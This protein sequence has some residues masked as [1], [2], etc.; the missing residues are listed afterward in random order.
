MN[1]MIVAAAGKRPLWS[2]RIAVIALA[3]III[4][5]MNLGLMTAGSEFGRI[6]W[7]LI[8]L[9][10]RFIHPAL[11]IGAVAIVSLWTAV[12]SHLWRQ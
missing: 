7:L 2:K 9:G 5:L 1:S 6:I 12:I 3:V 8:K 4:F 11:W 10:F